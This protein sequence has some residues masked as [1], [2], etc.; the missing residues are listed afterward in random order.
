M[1]LPELQARGD[2][3]PTRATDKL[4]GIVIRQSLD[5]SPGPGLPQSPDLIV[6]GTAAAFDAGLFSDPDAK[7]WVFQQ[8]PTFGQ[9]NYLYVRGTNY[10][11]TGPQ[12]SRIYLYYAQSDQLLDPSKWQ[13]SGFSVGGVSQNYVGINAAATYQLVATGTP[14]LWTPPQPSTAGAS[15]VLISWI[16]NSATPRPPTLPATPFA[17]AAAL[18]A[19]LQA[20]AQIAIADTQFRGAFL[21]Q[22][23]SQGSSQGGAGAQTSPDLIVAGVNATQ[24]ASAY[25]S[26]PSYGST[27]LNNQAA[28]DRRNFVY[29]RAINTRPGAGRSRVYLYW[30][31]TAAPSPANWQATNFSYAGQPRNWVD[32]SYTQAGQIAVST[33][34]L[35]WTPPAQPSGQS[36][37]LAAYVDNSSAP[38]APDLSVFSYFTT[39]AVTGFLAQQPQLAWLAVGAATAP[40]ISMSMEEAINVSAAGNCY[41]GVQLRNIPTDGTVS[42]SIPGADAASTVVAPAMT[43][44]ASGAAVVWPV[45]YP[46]GL[47]TSAVL[48][49]TQGATAPPAQAS[50]SIVLLEE[51]GIGAKVSPVR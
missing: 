41:V 18:E 5:K 4:T 44:P 25:T 7:R 49:Y 45:T 17:N 2:I 29:V 19:Y 11:S 50:F 28:A 15:Y 1:H 46:A 35:V 30:T 48:T 43:V 47:A 12:T 26:Q 31:S 14:V 51:P 10:T 32:L 36:W 23:P 37:I 16:D 34:P 33:I 9:A 40:A 22:A 38:Q 3:D 20:N 8:Q 6:T 39:K 27:T 21:R 42:L 24:D 13:S